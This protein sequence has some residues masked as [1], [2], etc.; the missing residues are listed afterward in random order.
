MDATLKARLVK[1][2]KQDY[3]KNGVARSFTRCEFASETLG[4]FQARINNPPEKYQAFQEVVLTPIYS[5]FNGNLQLSFD[6]A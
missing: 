5:V 4:T 2:T 6:L 3:E 1:V